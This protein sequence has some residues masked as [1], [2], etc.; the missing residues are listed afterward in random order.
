MGIIKRQSLKTSI[1]N[2]IG[3]LIGVVFFNFVFPHL[4]SEEYLGLIGLLQNLT[5]IFISI[6]AL[7]LA[8]IIFRYFS[9][10]KESETVNYF[11]AFALLAMSGGIILF[12][13]F[14]LSISSS[15]YREL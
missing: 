15:N 7:G 2:Y 14:L 8:Q 13:F 6:P 5:Y 3:V 1:V 12:A 10:W 11:N 9:V 4:V